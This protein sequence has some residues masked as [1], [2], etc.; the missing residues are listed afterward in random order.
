MD[1]SFEHLSR[2]F[3]YITQ[4]GIKDPTIQ[5]IDN[6]LKN[7]KST[8]DDLFAVEGLWAY[9]KIINSPVRI[10]AFI[11]CIDFI[12]NSNMLEMVKGL[13]KRA[14][15]S[16]LISGKLCERISS[17][18][19][20]QGFFMLCS[21]RKANLVD[22]E[23]KEHNLLVV[24]D[25]LEKPGN[26]GTIIRSLDA[27]GGDGLIL[28]NSRVRKTNP[29]LIK[30]SM[31]SSFKV[32]VIETDIDQVISWL[33]SNGFRIV[34]TDLMAKKSCYNIN[35]QGR[36]A[37]IVGNEIRGISYKWHQHKCTRVIIPMF[38]TADSLNA[39]VAASIV[40]FEASLSQRQIIR[41]CI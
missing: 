6:L 7:K 15:K 23:L 29:K 32:P 28:C 20:S 41:K 34:V 37:I 13:V 16:Y 40:I 4:V 12:K 1:L 25:G 3:S 19:S 2:E 22:I 27:A 14:E 38:G 11:F 30:S 17:R 18:D 5:T 26:I 31:G 9:E 8:D 35:Y 10:K 36:T 24:L 21:T 39:G 33:S